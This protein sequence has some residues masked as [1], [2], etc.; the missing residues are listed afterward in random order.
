M[1]KKIISVCSAFLA[2]LTVLTAFAACAKD[3][4]NETTTAPGGSTAAPE[5]TVAETNP[6]PD[7]N[8][9]GATFKILGAHNAYEPN[10]EIV[11]EN[12]GDVMSSE[13]FK[14][15]AFIAENYNVEIS[16]VGSE[17]DKPVDMLKMAI[18]SGEKPYD[19][20]FL[21]RNYMAT[22]IVNGYLQNIKNVDYINLENAWYTQSTIKSMEIG[23]KLFHMVSD[24]SIVDKC[25][26]NVLYYNREL[27]ADKKY[28]DFIQ[29]VR[30]GSWTIDEMLK[31]YKSTDLN[32]DGVMD[33]NDEWAMTLGG[34]E[35]AVAFWSACGNLN[36]TFAGDGSWEITA[37]SERS[38]NTIEKIRDLFTDDM[39]F[40]G[41]RWN[42]WSSS[43]NTFL[44]GRALFMTG[45]LSSIEYLGSDA[46]FSFSAIPFPKYDKD[47][48]NY[49][50]TND[51]TYTATMAIPVCAEDA[52]F[53]GF[54]IELLS[55]RSSTSTLPTYIELVCKVK[56]SYDATCAE[57]LDLILKG[58]TFDFGL[59]NNAKTKSKVLLVALYDKSVD[60]TSLYKTVEN[61]VKEKI[62]SIFDAVEAFD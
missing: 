32:G 40:N 61:E 53:T 45:G 25:R 58:V 56:K 57:M 38:I 43:S 59:I 5:T 46:Q 16:D 15:N 20:V 18:D 11:G 60:A 55:W 3:P 8:W 2:I 17:T 49:I 6:V 19:M 30:E 28:P 24:F 7:T 21:I 47:Q 34:K 36:V 44:A 29:M 10:F 54:M 12:N 27:A 50:T 51:N 14:R 23:G 48:E 37:A 39:S 22:S 35:A 1:T 41:G 9:N 31:Y 42:D 4:G 62:Q 52:D 26:T 13:V 33:L